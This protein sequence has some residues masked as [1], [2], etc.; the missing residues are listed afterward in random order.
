[1]EFL[2]Q[3]PDEFLALTFY[4]MKVFWRGD[5]ERFNYYP[6]YRDWEG[7]AYV[8]VS[9]LGLIGLLLAVEKRVFG[10]LFF[11]IVLLCYPVVYYV[12]Y[13]GP[14]YRHVIEPELL[15]LSTFVLTWVVQ[16][17]IEKFRNRK[18]TLQPTRDQ[19]NV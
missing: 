14:R 18:G 2:R 15:L 8:S 17:A 7:W 1:M 4:R 5:P 12:T 3:Y 11:G 19:V 16:S 13:P 10:A 6:D 9:A